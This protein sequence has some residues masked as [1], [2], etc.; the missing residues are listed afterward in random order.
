MKLLFD[1][2][3]SFK[4]CDRLANLFPGSSQVRLLGLAESHRPHD[5]GLRRAQRLYVGFA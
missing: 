5:L 3:L 2:N 4:L 1:E